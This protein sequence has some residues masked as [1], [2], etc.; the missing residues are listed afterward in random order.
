M[1]TVRCKLTNTVRATIQRLAASF[2][3]LGVVLLALVMIDVDL[4]APLAAIFLIGGITY[5]LLPFILSDLLAAVIPRWPLGPRATWIGAL[6]V[7]ILPPLVL[8]F[9]RLAPGALDGDRQRLALIVGVGVVCAVA[10]FLMRRRLGVP[11]A[12]AGPKVVVAA[13]QLM[14]VFL[15]MHLREGTLSGMHERSTGEHLLLFLGTF[16]VSVALLPAFALRIAARRETGGSQRWGICW[17]GVAIVAGVAMLVADRKSMVGLHW[18]AHVWMGLVGILAVDTGLVLVRRVLLARRGSDGPARSGW[19]PAVPAAALL[20]SAFIYLLPSVLREIDVRAAIDGS[21]HRSMVIKAHPA[22]SAG[23]LLPSDITEHEMLD[24]PRYHELAKDRGYNVVLVSVD[25][26]RGDL[27]DDIQNPLPQME[28][29]AKFA[30]QATHF[31]RAY[32]PGSRTALSTSAVLTGRYSANLDWELWVAKGAMPLKPRSEWDG[33]PGAGYGHTTFAKPVPGGGLAARLSE[34]GLFTLAVPYGGRGGFFKKGVGFE[35]GFDRYVSLKRGGLGLPSSANVT[36]R[37]LKQL[38]KIKN[39][40]F[41]LWVHYF[42]PHSARKKRERYDDLTKAFD[43]GFAGL[44]GGLKRRELWDSTILVV[45]ADHGEAFGDH[46]NYTHGSSLY[47]EQARVP[48]IIRV[49]GAP[50]RSVDLPVST[51]D[52]TATI[53]AMCGAD[54]SEIDGVNLAP[55]IDGEAEADERPVFTELHRFLAASGRRTADLKAVAMGCKKLIYN[56][57]LDEISLFDICEDPRELDNV[58]AQQR[59]TAR[60]LLEVLA[61]FVNRGEREHPLP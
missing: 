19:G 43:V 58:V 17:A 49:P 60:E 41:F 55:V 27:L 7:L 9:V 29:L 46:G 40:R 33:E 24:Y 37:A 38:D 1:R 28:N 13:G 2:S 30:R 15:Y 52:A 47:D 39:D 22:H 25:A 12:E 57:R 10:L 26:L 23:G 20:V 8:A 21:P 11:E 54:L 6:G 5:T 14:G 45:I 36:K 16:G 56:R 53:L 3:T 50:P 31:R 4:T 44:V 35:R 48:L 61:A 59:E 18:S 32:A 42:D 51:I 34:R